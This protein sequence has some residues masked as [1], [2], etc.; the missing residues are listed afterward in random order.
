VSKAQTV[1]EQCET[2]LDVL[3]NTPNP[4]GCPAEIYLPLQHYRHNVLHVYNDN[5]P[6]ETCPLTAAFREAQ[7]LA[8]PGRQPPY[9]YGEILAA[10]S[11]QGD[12]K[13]TQ[14]FLSTVIEQLQQVN[15]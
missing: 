1:Q 7:R 2:A 14:T 11:G 5:T 13:K 10:F 6:P 3:T 4:G 15:E 9:V 12:K 8:Y